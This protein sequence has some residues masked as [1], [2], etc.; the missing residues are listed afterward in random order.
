LVSK[1]SKCI[2]KYNKKIGTP[3]D[4][5]SIEEWEYSS[6]QKTIRQ[7]AIESF[8]FAVDSL[9][10]KFETDIDDKRKNE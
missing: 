5:Y 9:I 3:I 8:N 7:S 6:T 1:F 10:K 2:E 4:C